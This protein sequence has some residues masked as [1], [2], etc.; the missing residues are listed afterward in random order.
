[1]IDKQRNHSPRWQPTTKLLVGLTGL[2]LLAALSVRFQSVLGMLVLSAI[3]SFVMAPLVGWLQRQARLSWTAATNISFL[4]LILFL[5]LISTAAG[6]AVVQQLQALIQTTQG[7]LSELP[8]QIEPLGPQLVEIGPWTLDLS[9]FDPSAL[10]EQALSYV[11]PVFT[12]ASALITGL[13][14]VALG[15]IAR[16]LFILVVAYFLTLD[17]ERFRRAW[18]TFAIPGYEADFDRLRSALARLWNSFLRGQLLVVAI[19]GILTWILMSVLGLRFSLG[20]GVLGG[21]AK[22]VPIVGPTIAGTIAALVAL[23]QPTNWLGLNPIAHALIVALSVTL[24]DQSIDYLVVPRIFGSSLNLHPVIIIIGAIVGATLAGVLG[25]L[26]SAPSMATAI[27]LGRYIIRKMFDQSPWDPPIDTLPEIP[28]RS[29][30]KLLKRTK[31][32]VEEAR[33]G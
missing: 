1:M 12:R 17:N 13:A 22:F 8:E 25:L 23:F 20:L 27:L 19:V 30:S 11:E 7:V 15:T 32:I 29:L 21:I 10:L 26:L 31:R 14:T 16:L 28:E 9:E 24:L 3:I 5:L 4:F 33:E 18:S 2:I 6:F